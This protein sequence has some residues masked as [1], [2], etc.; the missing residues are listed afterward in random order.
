V[1]GKYIG[2]A[3]SLRRTFFDGTGGPQKLLNALLEDKI[4]LEKATEIVSGTRKQVF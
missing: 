3:G 1:R 4:S 2:P